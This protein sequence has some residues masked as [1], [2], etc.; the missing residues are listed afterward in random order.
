[1]ASYRERNRGSKEFQERVQAKLRNGVDV[2]SLST[3]ERISIGIYTINLV[4]AGRARD[5]AEKMEAEK[6]LKAK[7]KM[8]AEKMM[9]AAKKMEAAKMVEPE[10]DGYEIPTERPKPSIKAAPTEDKTSAS[11]ENG[12]QTASYK[13]NRNE[14][15]VPEKLRNVTDVNSL[16]LNERISLGIYTCALGGAARREKLEATNMME[17]EIHG[18][19]EK[20]PTEGPKPSVEA[21]PTQRSRKE[22]S[23]ERR[24]TKQMN[25]IETLSIYDRVQLGIYTWRLGQG[26]YN[27]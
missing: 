22:L 20:I 12:F 2:N 9:E 7:K 1:M 17:P 21:A 11:S 10:R 24:K 18:C 5:A 3:I 27:P 8:E 16:P 14:K 19:E 25:Y 23:H 13:R 4:A 6:K 26:I 15:S